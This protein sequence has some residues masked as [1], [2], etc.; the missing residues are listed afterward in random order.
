V[1]IAQH[2]RQGWRALLVGAALV[3][4]ASAPA[5]SALGR[6]SQPGGQQLGFAAPAE[7]D[8]GPFTLDQAVAKVRKQHPKAE[9]VSAETRDGERGKVHV[10][11]ALRQNGKLKVYRFDAATGA[12]LD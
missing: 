2:P 4:V 1:T 3:L 6:W 7:P 8:R 10:V 9:I 12:E 11:K 5:A